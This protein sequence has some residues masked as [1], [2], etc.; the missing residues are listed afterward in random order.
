MFADE[1][2]SFDP[3]RFAEIRFDLL[4]PAGLTTS[5]RVGLCRV[6][7]L[8]D[9]CPRCDQLYSPRECLLWS[10]LFREA[11]RI[12]LDRAPPCIRNAFEVRRIRI[13]TDFLVRAGLI[14]P[15]HYRVGFRFNCKRM[16]EW[17]YCKPDEYCAAISHGD[18]MDYYSARDRVKLSR[19]L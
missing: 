3:D 1:F 7:I 6:S 17:G 9:L 15:P 5:A 18:P 10:R 11:R 2:G 16:R 14:Q 19:N 8:A 13:V 4:K 12:G